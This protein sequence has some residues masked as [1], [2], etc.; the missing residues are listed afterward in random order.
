MSDVDRAKKLHE[1][2]GWRLDD[3]IAL[4][5]LSVLPRDEADGWLAGGQTALVRDI[6]DPSRLYGVL[7]E[8]RNLGLELV[9]VEAVP[10]TSQSN[11]QEWSKWQN[12]ST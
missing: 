3:N 6:L 4:L 12:D 10:D 7:E 1:H 2:L 5:S 9:S 11:E 8:T